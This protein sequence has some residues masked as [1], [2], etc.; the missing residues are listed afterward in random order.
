M[1]LSILHVY[2]HL[3]VSLLSDPC[4]LLFLCRILSLFHKCFSRV[5]I[6]ILAFWCQICCKYFPVCYYFKSFLMVFFLFKSIFYYCIYYSFKCM[7]SGFYTLIRRDSLT[8]RLIW[9]STY[10]S[11]S[12]FRVFSKIFESFLQLE[13]I[14]K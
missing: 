4:P 12:T 11:L 8:V 2:C 10:V 7:V 9:K 13:F 1:R 14:F 5:L 6:R 3:N